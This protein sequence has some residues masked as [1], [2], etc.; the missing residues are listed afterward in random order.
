MDLVS[1][2]REMNLAELRAQEVE[3]RKNWGPL[4]RYNQPKNFANC[5][6]YF[7]LC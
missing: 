7:W 6:V 4:K 1:G 3:E 5:R 2:R